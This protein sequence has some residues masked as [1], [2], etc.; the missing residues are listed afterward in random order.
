MKYYLGLVVWSW[1]VSEIW[2][3]FTTY[4]KQ[5]KNNDFSNLKEISEKEYH[6]LKAQNKHFVYSI[7]R[8]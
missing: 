7:N 1:V 2:D 6:R 8:G 3:Q 5:V 4:E